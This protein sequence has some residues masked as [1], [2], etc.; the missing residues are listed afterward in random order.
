MKRRRPRQRT[1][2]ASLAVLISVNGSLVPAPPGAGPVL[3]PDTVRAEALSVA[4]PDQEETTMRLGPSDPDELVDFQVILSQPGRAEL[5]VFLAE[6]ADPASPRYW[7]YLDPEAFG[8]RFG[9]P[10]EA[11]EAVA[12]SLEAAGLEVLRR[13]AGRTFLAARGRVSDV[14]ALF[15]IELVDHLDAKLGRYRVPDVEPLV[16]AELRDSVLGIAGLDTTPRIRPMFVPPF[17]DVPMG[18]LLPRAGALAYDY[19]PLHDAGITGQGQTVAILSFDTFLDSDV[20]AFDA[21]VGVTAPPVERR[22]VPQ[23]YE[24]VLGDG[25][26]EVNLDIDVVRAIAPAAQ[27]INYEAA[28]ATGFAEVFAAI[29][30]DGRADII[31]VSWGACEVDAPAISRAFIDIELERAFAQGVSIFASSGDTGVFSCAHRRD[32]DDE[33]VSGVY[34][35]TSPQAISVGGTFLW[36]REDGTY[37]REAAWEEPFGKVATGGGPSGSYERPGWQVAPGVDTSPGALRQTPD[38]AG[39]ADGESGYVMVHTPAGATEPVRGTASGTSA[40]PPFWAASMILIR[41]LAEQEGVGPLGT[42]GPTLYEPA[43][44]PAD[45]PLF[46]DVE[47]GGNLRDDAGPGWD[48]A[49]GL[50]SPDVTA[51]ARAIIELLAS[52]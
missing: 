35:S 17:A 38:V 7:R 23:D 29:L 36:V 41:Q 15:G 33:R 34:P 10:D 37:L 2:I 51:L 11:V 47:L 4:R 6:V 12:S 21:A 14:N 25:S 3:P 26:V 5:D 32:D 18:E 43:A 31:S 1:A 44:Q 8:Q 42:L 45:P 50:G 30:D 22:P 27:I 49:T 39:P 52:R 40:A 13:D 48:A 16:P 28:N 19:A 20:A 46:H 24:A 9:L